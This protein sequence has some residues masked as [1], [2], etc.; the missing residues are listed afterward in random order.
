MQGKLPAGS[1]RSYFRVKFSLLQCHVCHGPQA[2]WVQPEVRVV[3]PQPRAVVSVSLTEEQKI[4]A[5]K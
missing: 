2:L 5:G 1:G 3:P 4:E